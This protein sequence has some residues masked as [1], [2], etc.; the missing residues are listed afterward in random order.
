MTGT[1][2]AVIPAEFYALKLS[3]LTFVS[4]THAQTF[5]PFI[6]NKLIKVIVNIGRADWPMFYPDFF[7][8]LL[9]LAS[10]TGPHGDMRSV[11]VTALMM[12]SEEFTSPRE[13]VSVQR[14]RE[15]RQ[16]MLEQV[17]MVLKICT[18]LFHSTSRCL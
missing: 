7:D 15:L 4:L 2:K 17:P 18:G 13:D 16:L 5:P 8:N 12:T 9:H 14:K 10:S 1:M 11:G 3:F 6:V